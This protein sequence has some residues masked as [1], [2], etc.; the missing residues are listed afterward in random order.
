MVGAIVNEQGM[1]IGFSADS[2]IPLPPE[3]WP[4]YIPVWNGNEWVVVEDYRETTVY[5]TEDGTEAKVEKVGPIP[6][7]YTMKAPPGQFS[8]WNGY[9]WVF[10]RGKWMD[11]ELKPKR[12]ALIEQVMWRVQRWEREERMG[13]KHHDDIK[14][15]DAYVQE[16]CDL[17]EKVGEKGE[18]EWPKVSEEI[19]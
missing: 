6:D 11:M 17:P 13:L 1:Y 12:N 18:V 10:D 2:S 15:L 7:G 19:A 14:A 4:P 5:K 8:S 3:T 9:E 16:L